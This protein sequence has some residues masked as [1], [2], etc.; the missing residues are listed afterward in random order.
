MARIAAKVLQRLGDRTAGDLLGE[1]RGGGHRDRAAL[2]VI[3]DVFDDRRS[4]RCRWHPQGHLVTARG[5]DVVHLRVER[6][7]QTGA[8]RVA[9][10][11][12]RMSCW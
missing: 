6:L 5:V 11:W 3:R 10:E 1:D 4:R 2:R 9:L 8:V 7:T 12:S